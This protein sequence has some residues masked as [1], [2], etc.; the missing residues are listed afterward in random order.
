MYETAPDFFAGERGW[1][2]YTGGKL[3]FFP[4]GGSADTITVLNPQTLKVETTFELEG[5]QPLL[6]NS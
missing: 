3:Y 1:L 5:L 2:G 6:I 4:K